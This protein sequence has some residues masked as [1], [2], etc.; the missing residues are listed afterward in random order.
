MERESKANGRN[1]SSSDIRF[2][3]KAAIALS[4]GYPHCAWVD[5]AA[6]TLAL[7]VFLALMGCDRPQASQVRLVKAHLPRECHLT[8]NGVRIPDNVLVAKG[9]EQRGKRAVASV[10]NDEP[11]SCVGAT[12][13]LQQAGMNIHELPSLD[14]RS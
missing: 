1:G 11:D 5:R 10:G 12:F 14:L 13:M 2:G 6:I 4:G 9:K 7:S 8:L 3:W